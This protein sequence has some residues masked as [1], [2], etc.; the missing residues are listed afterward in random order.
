MTGPPWRGSVWPGGHSHW[1]YTGHCLETDSLGDKPRWGA[2]PSFWD[3]NAPW[4][5]VKLITRVRRT[6]GWGR[7]AELDSPARLPSAHMRPAAS[8]TLCPASSDGDATI[9]TGS[10]SPPSL[11]PS[12][13]SEAT[14]STALGTKTH[15]YNIFEYEFFYHLF[16]FNVC[17]LTVWRKSDSERKRKVE[18]VMLR[19]SLKWSQEATE[20]GTFACP[21]LDGL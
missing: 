17:I 21:S 4:E 18:S 8:F 6:W 16:G 20:D 14:L 3:V 12:P 5:G 11:P 10:S 2:F 9:H 7:V 13:G 19:G 1:W 15:K